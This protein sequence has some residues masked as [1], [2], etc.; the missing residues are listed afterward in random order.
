MN[1]DIIECIT[2]IIFGLIVTGVAIMVAI[3]PPNETLRNLS[4]KLNKINN[5]IENTKDKIHDID[6]TITAMQNDIHSLNDKAYIIEKDL[7]K[8][9]S[10][11]HKAKNKKTISN[12]KKEDSN[13][14]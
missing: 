9:L 3:I 11:S 7:F 14:E 1:I 13:N 5:D 6:E 10:K 12:D 8:A 2:L 4:N